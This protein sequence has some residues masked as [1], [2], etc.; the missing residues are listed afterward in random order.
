MQ[1]VRS[2]AWL[3]PTDRSP[4]GGRPVTEQRAEA[5]PAA[6]AASASAQD[7]ILAIGDSHVHFWGGT[8]APGAAA[9]AFSGVDLLHI[10]PATAR[11]LGSSTSATAAGPGIEA[12]L[13]QHQGRYGCLLFCFGEVDCRVHIVRHALSAGLTLDEAALDVA[14]RYFSY[15]AD[16]RQRTGLPC[17]LWGPAPAAPSGTPA[18][19]PEFPAAGSAVERNYAT[20][21]L[22]A[23]LARLAA[24]TSGVEH[25]GL[26]DRLVDA[27]GVTRPGA[28]HDGRHL[29]P[30]LLDDAV[31][32]L[33]GALDRLGCLARLGPALRRWPVLPAAELRNIAAG[34][35]YKASSA[36]GSVHPT[37]FASAPGNGVMFHTDIEDQPYI[38]FE[39]DASYCIKLIKVHNRSDACQH[40]ARSLAIAA[41][42]DG[43]NWTEVYAPADFKPPGW[44]PTAACIALPG[45]EF[46]RFVRLFL[47]ERAYFHLECVEILVRTFNAALAVPKEPVVVAASHA[48][49]SPSPE[50]ALA[51]PAG[52]QRGSPDLPRRPGQRLRILL[53][54]VHPVLEYDEVQMFEEMGHEVFCLGFYTRRGRL[55]TLRG[56]LPETDWHHACQEAFVAHGCAQVRGDVQWRVSGAFCAGFDV[57]LVHHNFSFIA[58]NWQALAASR[59]IWRTIGQGIHWAEDRMRD[60]RAQGLKIVRWSP[61]ERHIERYIGA[62]AVIRTAKN[63]AD[64]NRWTGTAGRIVTF[65]NNFRARGQGM[66]FDFHQQCVAGLPFDLYGIGNEDVPDWR[67]VASPDE[68]VRLLREHRVAFVTGTNPAPY[69]L[70]FVEAWMTGTPVVHVGRR[71]FSGGAR[72]V[73]EID[74]LI[75][76][77]ESGFLVDEVDAAAALFR[78]LLGNHA[79][80][81]QVSA[82]GRAA[83]VA[84]FGRATAAAQWAAFFK[85]HIQ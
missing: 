83:A 31:A 69:T 18:F 70:G 66:S 11:D 4:R 19:D 6:A 68:Q 16:L 7:R 23:Q 24:G 14:E 57:V 27:A 43:V 52:E 29:S 74:H 26:F 21:R 78:E 44:G 79:L 38:L 59:V 34:W 72:G 33:H 42:D 8:D 55:D 35:P 5:S 50:P 17:V 85:E 73:Y 25:I 84:T 39:F 54:S 30:A 49:P 58:E 64:W 40:R 32:L 80:C 60:Y 10:G 3:P 15:I 51:M 45:N 48:M 61:E 77:G 41:S 46:Y 75:V 13:Q 71:R 81:A 12:H 2:E 9:R 37:P 82:K 63:P 36:T 62:D 22:N 28:L 76:D 53:V 56:P 20:Q 65:N 47:R 67:G 1:D